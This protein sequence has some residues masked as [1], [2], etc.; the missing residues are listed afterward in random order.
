ML[1]AEMADGIRWVYG[2]SGLRRLAVATQVWFAA[3]AVLQ[4]VV[5]PFAYLQLGLSSVALGAVLALAGVGAV[6]GAATSTLVGRGFG[7]VG[8]I[9]CSYA[10]SGV[11]VLVMLTAALEPS[12]WSTALLGVGQLA[13]GWAMGLGNSHEMTFRQALTPDALQARTNTTMRS[14]NRAV[15]VL[16]SPVAGLLAQRFGAPVALG[17]SSLVFATAAGLLLFSPLRSARID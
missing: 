7:T 9:I 2:G 15:L 3:Q 14:L 1:F 16:V 12:D 10:V 8:A 17:L 5:V 6:A 11:G 13:H 4:V